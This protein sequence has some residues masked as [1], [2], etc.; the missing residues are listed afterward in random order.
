M[1]KTFLMIAFIVALGAQAI[2]A[3]LNIRTNSN[4][5]IKVLIDGQVVST[6]SATVS[7]NNLR[8][9]YHNMQVFHILRNYNS[10]NEEPI[11]IG[12][13]FLPNQTV[14]NALVRQNQFIVE[15]QFALN[16]PPPPHHNGGNYDNVPHGN[17]PYGNYYNTKPVTWTTNQHPNAPAPVVVHYNA[18]EVVQVFPMNAQVFNQL[19]ASINNQWFS[20]GKMVVFNQAVQANFFTTAQVNELINLFSFS[21]DR[22][23]VAKKAY[24]KTVDPE[25]YFMVYNSLQWNS[26]IQ[27]LS[28]YIASL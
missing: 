15:Q 10:Y 11:F 27:S 18:P 28:N 19:K 25:N 26:S 9:G 13:I 21:N 8:S 7:L 4:A 17:A 23:E 22:L 5:P 16:T 24:T 2:A 14:T 3:D 6:N 1:K 12:Q 20:D